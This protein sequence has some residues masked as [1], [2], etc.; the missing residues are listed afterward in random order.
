MY[1]DKNFLNEVK[2]NIKSL[3][4]DVDLHALSRIWSHHVSKHKWVYNF[5]WMDMPIIQSPTDG[6]AMQEI[7]WNIKP[8]LIIETGIARGGSL[9]FYASLLAQIDLSEAIA[10]KETYDF[11]KSSRKVLGI[12]ID[13]RESNRRDIEN[14]PMGAYIE[15]FEGSSISSEIINQVKTYSK[16]F[17]K[18]LVVLDSNHT[19][20]HVLSELVAFSELV[21]IGSY[22]V[23][24]DTIIDDLPVD[25]F[26]NR[27][28]GKGN[29]PK[30]AVNE[31]LLSRKDF[32][33]DSDIHHKLLITAAPDG[34][35][36]RI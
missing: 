8:D 35:L 30:S 18:I 26:E 10:R 34:F 32:I 13:I 21:S 29:S 3:S 27:P 4:A 15:M 24:F 20:D 9:V 2:N 23:V 36:K 5:Q 6:W 14:H 12:D 25:D 16:K 1:S 17:N 31:F 22:C 19:H 33:I 7:I 11:R 28:W